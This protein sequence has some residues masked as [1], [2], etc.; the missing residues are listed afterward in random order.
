VGGNRRGSD[1][2]GKVVAARRLQ[3]QHIGNLRKV[4]E[5]DREKIRTMAKEQGVAAAVEAIMGY[6]G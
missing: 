6:L 1:R 4:A 5:K 2:T 3:G